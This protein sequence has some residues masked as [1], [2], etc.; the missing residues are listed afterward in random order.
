MKKS[1][2]S[3]SI[4]MPNVSNIISAR[5]LNRSL[6]N[7]FNSL[8][9]GKE[10]FYPFFLLDP[11]DKETLKQAEFPEVFGFKIH[12]SILQI[13]IDDPAWRPFFKIAAER[14]LPILVHCGRNKISS[15]YH[16][17]SASLMNPENIFIGAHLGGNAS[18]LINIA[19]DTIKKTKLNNLFLDTSAVKLPSLIEK[20]VNDLGEDK[21][22]FGSDEPYSD[23]RVSLYCMKLSNVKH[24]DKIFYK[25]I[26]GILKNKI[27]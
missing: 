3:K 21:I 15:I 16:L 22:V 19:I 14:N 18:D 26:Q 2:I 7:D 13:S 23:L 20:A 25:N 11:S 6:L 27:R 4:V 17:I 10:Y 1:G 8:D 9:Q 24:K 12:P 5:D